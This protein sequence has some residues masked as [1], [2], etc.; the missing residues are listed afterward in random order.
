M[1]RL[2]LLLCFLLLCHLAFPFQKKRG[3][4]K[5]DLTVVSFNIRYGTPGD[6]INIW[7]NR[8]SLIFNIFKKYKT[9]IIAT[10][11]AL[12]RQIDELK[13]EIPKMGVV[14]RTRQEDDAS[15]ES[16]AI[17]YDKKLWE[18]VEDETFWFSDTPEVPGSRS[19]GN[20]L[21]RITTVAVFKSKTT[22]K[23]IRILNTHLD[24]RSQNSREKSVD[25]IL[26]KIDNY[27]ASIPTIIVGDFNVLPDD[28]ILKSIR[29]K[30]EDTYTGLPIEGCTFH[31]WDGGRHCQRVDYI[32]FPKNSGIELLDSGIDRYSKGGRFPSDHFPVFAKFKLN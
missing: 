4:V 24:H 5:P 10:Q 9:G 13:V 22:G 30:Y 15:G 2:S 29:A 17:F 25:L 7:K 16:M 20:S 19:W 6:G 21:P 28:P 18:A 14:Y 31:K 23:K 26:S 12:R 32:F 1:K 8:K 3:K 27:D 11:E